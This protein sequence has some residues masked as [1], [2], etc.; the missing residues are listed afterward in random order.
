MS[1]NSVSGPGIST[2]GIAAQISPSLRSLSVNRAASSVDRRG[3]TR[4][5]VPCVGR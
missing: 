3:G 4:G 5:E 2:F 1:P